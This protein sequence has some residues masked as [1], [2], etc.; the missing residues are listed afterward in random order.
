MKRKP[1]KKDVKFG[2]RPI[3]GAT[4]YTIKDGKKTKTLDLIKTKARNEN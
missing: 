4:R 3:I 1:K 2:F